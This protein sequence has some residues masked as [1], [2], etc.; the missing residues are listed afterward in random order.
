MD[1]A[2]DN[3]FF[4]LILLVCVGVHLF[5]GHGGHGGHRGKHQHDPRERDGH[6]RG[7]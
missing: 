1:W 2:T 4:L 6:G 5:H 7:D 3:S